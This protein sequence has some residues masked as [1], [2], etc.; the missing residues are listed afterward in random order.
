MFNDKKILAL[1]PARGGSKGIKNKNII[2]LAGKPLIAWTIEAARKSIF[3]DDVIITTDSAEIASVAKKFGGDAPFLRPPEL[4][5]D[6]SNTIDAVLHALGE[7]KKLKKFYDALVL[8][9]PT[10]PLRLPEDIDGA[11]ETFFKNSELPLASVSP[12]KDHPVLIRSLSSDKKTLVPLLNL[13]STCRRQDMPDYYRVNGCIYINKLNEFNELNKNTS[14]NDNIIAFV[15]PRERSVDID[16]PSDIAMAE[17][18]INNF[19]K[20]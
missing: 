8:L 13:N 12:V 18:Y 10:Q 19:N 4:A 1:I 17:Y 9:Q 3:I 20:N 14:F 6:K 5:G 11:I 16:E 7:L 15:M 2:N